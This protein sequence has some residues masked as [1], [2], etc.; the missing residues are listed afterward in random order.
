MAD[1]I[2]PTAPRRGR[3][4]VLGDHVNADVLH[5][6]Q[7]FSLDD[8]RV[9][10]GFLGA[11]GGERRESAGLEASDAHASRAARIVVAGRNF[12]CGSSR[13]TTV[14]SFLLAGVV[15]VVAESFGRLFVRNATGLGLPTWKLA[16]PARDLVDGESLEI[17]A[18]DPP[19]LVRTS[20]GTRHRLVPRDPFLDAVLAAGGLLEYLAEPSR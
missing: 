6:S 11:L 2:E 14:R 9:R 1:P 19:V 18:Y 10:S 17:R 20:C 13:E 15:A 12:G 4:L 16:E 8:G 7:F 5:P 3:A